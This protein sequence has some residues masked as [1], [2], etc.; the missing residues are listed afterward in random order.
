MCGK[1]GGLELAG[2]LAFVFGNQQFDI[3]LFVFSL[4]QDNGA[5]NLF[6]VVVFEVDLDGE[7]AHQA[8]EVRHV[9]EGALARADDHQAAIHLFAQGF[10]DFLNIE[11]GLRVQTDELLHLIEYQERAGHFAINRNRFADGAAHFIHADVV[12]VRVSGPKQ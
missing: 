9:V 4:L 6:N 1:L 5:D 10:D 8:L 11:G 12:H 3:G 2:D 7:A